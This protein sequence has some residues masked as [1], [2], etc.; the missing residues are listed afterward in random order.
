MDPDVYGCFAADAGAD[1]DAGAGGEAVDVE[2][3]D[4]AGDHSGGGD[5]EAW[6]SQLVELDLGVEGMMAYPM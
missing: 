5:E 1:F 2:L 3:H 6:I 4:G